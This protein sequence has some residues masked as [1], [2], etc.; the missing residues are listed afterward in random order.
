[1][2]NRLSLLCTVFLLFA[3]VP[4]YAEATNQDLKDCISGSSDHAQVVKACTNALTRQG[5]ST[6]QR[7]I[8]LNYRGMAHHEAG[9]YD[10]AIA[11]Y[12]EALGGYQHQVLYFNRGKSWDEKGDYPKAIGDYSEAIERQPDWVLALSKRGILYILTKD[13]ERAITDFDRVIG[14]RPNSSDAYSDRGAAYEIWGKLDQAKADFDKALE[15]SPTNV[16][17]L[18]S[19]AGIALFEKDDATYIRFI[20]RAIELAPD[21]AVLFAERCFAW[22]RQKQNQKAEVDCATAVKLDPALAEPLSGNHKGPVSLS[23]NRALKSVE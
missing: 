5:I 15:I 2:F 1:M 12:S 8:Y 13:F 23:S 18:V 20:T 19:R 11:D 10:L 17:A 22:R 9:E 7:A 14:L 4:A 6:E 16:D 3:A 21:R